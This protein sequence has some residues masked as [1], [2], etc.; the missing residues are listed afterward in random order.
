M[1]INEEVVDVPNTASTSS[2]AITFLGVLVSLF[3]VR[4]IKEYE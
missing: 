2:F 3:G 1:S 4:W